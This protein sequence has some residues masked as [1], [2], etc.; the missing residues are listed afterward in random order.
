MASDESKISAVQLGDKRVEY[1]SAAE[2]LKQLN[3]TLSLVSPRVPIFGDS[4][5][6]DVEIQVL[7]CI[8]LTCHQIE[9]EQQKAGA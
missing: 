3:I 9:A 4:I 8:A 6:M 1:E 2:L 7:R 5:Y